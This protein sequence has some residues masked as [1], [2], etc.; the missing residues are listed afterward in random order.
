MPCVLDKEALRRETDRTRHSG[1]YPIRNLA[2]S[3][4]IYIRDI[5]VAGGIHGEAK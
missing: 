5:K 4:V 2:D 3:V 1:D